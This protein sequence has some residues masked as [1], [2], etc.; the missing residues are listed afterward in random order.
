[1]KSEVIESGVLAMIGGIVVL[2]FGLY[3][4][5]IGIPIL[6]ADSAILLLVNNI[7]E[8]FGQKPLPES[9]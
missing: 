9:G 4:D 6:E 8:F 1:M 2:I 5:K 3:E 7:V